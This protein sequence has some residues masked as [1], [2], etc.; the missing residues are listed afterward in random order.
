MGLQSQTLLRDFHFHYVIL[1]P[2]V[3]KL[4]LQE[5]STKWQHFFM[6]NS[7]STCNLER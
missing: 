4:L 5:V 2:E 1:A 3:L 7:V 6:P